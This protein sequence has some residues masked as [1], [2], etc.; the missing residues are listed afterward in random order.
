MIAQEWAQALDFLI[1]RDGR[2]VS[3]DGQVV[4]VAK[5]GWRFE[6]G[7]RDGGVIVCRRIVGTSSM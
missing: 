3:V 1:S 7:S 4:A 6:Y 2:E 5:V